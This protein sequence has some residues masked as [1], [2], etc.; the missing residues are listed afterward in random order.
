M[1]LFSTI[2]LGIKYAEI[3]PKERFLYNVFKEGYW[4]EAYEF[5]KRYMPPVLF[6]YIMWLYYFYGY[7]QY[8]IEWY[9]F[10]LPTIFVLVLLIG[11]IFFYWALGNK[12]SRKLT[13]R[14]KEWYID[15]CNYSDITPQLEPTIFDLIKVVNRAY[16]TEGSK[17]FLDKM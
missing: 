13:A 6:L 17:F 12:A 11:P 5:A 10:P 7:R 14:Q 4:I 8:S 15:V 9:V 1:S 2:K 16:K 3:F